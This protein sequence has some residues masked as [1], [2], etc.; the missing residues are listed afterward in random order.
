MIMQQWHTAKTIRHS[1]RHLTRPRVASKYS[2]RTASVTGSRCDNQKIFGHALHAS[3]WT[4]FPNSKSATAKGASFS[5][6][7]GPWWQ[8]NPWMLGLIHYCRS[9]EGLI[10]AKSWILYHFELSI[11]RTC[12][13]TLINTTQ[14]FHWHFTLYGIRIWAWHPGNENP[15]SVETKV[16][17]KKMMLMYILP[18]V[19]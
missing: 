4:A 8:T 1:Y 14:Q 17:G 13:H 15:W 18:T 3:S 11:W 2:L 16:W 9:A 7:M 19:M 12:S 10:S 6:L 5:G